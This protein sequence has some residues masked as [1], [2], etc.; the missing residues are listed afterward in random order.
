MQ[1]LE[2][3]QRGDLQETVHWWDYDISYKTLE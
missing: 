3:D 1:V 2:N